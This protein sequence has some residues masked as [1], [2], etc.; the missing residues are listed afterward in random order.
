MIAMSLGQ[1]RPWK[2]LLSNQTR[3]QILSV[4]TFLA[5]F[6]ALLNMADA[7]SMP[8]IL[9][10]LPSKVTVEAENGFLPTSPVTV[11]IE[12]LNVVDLYAWQVKL[13]FNSSIL[14]LTSN[15][16]W[17]PLSHVFAGRDFVPVSALVS[18][19]EK[20]AYTVFG[21]S[22]LG[23]ESSFSG[24]G[25]LCQ[26]NFT[27]IATGSSTLHFSKAL[28]KDVFLLDSNEEPILFA[29][30]DGGVNT[31]ISIEVSSQ[32]TTVQRYVTISGNIN[33]PMRGVNITIQFTLA[34]RAWDT[35]ATVTTDENSRF[36][37]TWRPTKEGTYKIRAHWAGDEN[38]NA[39]L[40]PTETV[41]VNPQ[42]N[43]TPLIA[44]VLLV[45]VVLLILT[46]VLK[47]RKQTPRH[48]QRI[49]DIQVQQPFHIFIARMDLCRYPTLKRT[50][51][52]KSQNLYVHIDYTTV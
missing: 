19:D 32:E 2:K 34:N 28:G 47:F 21:A 44:G 51:S 42:T 22:L 50:P 48:R 4:L 46:Y 45:T 10:V 17:Y 38:V 26:M 37:Y 24:S 5:F 29:V 8:T 20:G 12:V 41:K 1:T 16:V 30:F 14:N 15:Q 43:V 33:P 9:R 35:L 40:S 23:Q 11:K 31:A 13:Y 49:G 36:S 52:K 25:V 3:K 39:A 18:S 7:T 27:R 6:Y